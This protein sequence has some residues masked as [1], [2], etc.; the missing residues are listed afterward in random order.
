M[1]LMTIKN[2][3]STIK[4]FFARSKS[5]GLTELEYSLIQAPK[6][7]SKKVES[8]NDRDM[9]LLLNAPAL[10]EYR[11]DIKLRN[12]LLIQLGYTM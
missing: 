2:Y 7:A 9:Q 1:S 10:V 3:V 11:E 6:T 12:T 4:N 5:M 8:L